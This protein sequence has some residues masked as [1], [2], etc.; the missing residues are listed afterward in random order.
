MRIAF[1]ST[2]FGYPWGGADVLW[3]RAAARALAENHQVLVAVSA[4]CVVHPRIAALQAAGAELHV[5]TGFT[6]QR[7]R[8]EQWLQV[9][10]R[11][12]R[13]SRSLTAT[14]DRFQPDHLFLAQGGVFD[15][16]V[17]DGLVR[18]LAT[19]R[20]TCIPICQ[21]NDE[22]ESVAPSLQPAARQFLA[23]AKSTVFVSTH[24]RD[25]AGRQSGAPVP[26]AVVVA[27]PVEL[28]PGPPPPW[29]ANATPQLAIVAR[30]ESDPKGLDVLLQALARLGPGGDWHVDL[31]GRGPDEAA[32]RAEAARLGL[33][34][35]LSFSGYALN[36][37]QLWAD[38]H[39][40]LL[41]SRRE[42]CALAM[43]EALACGRPVLTTEIGGARDW[44]E[45]GVNGYL[46]PP[47]DT[48]AFATTLNKALA[49]FTRWPALGEG[50]RKIFLERHPDSP[51]AQLLALL[52]S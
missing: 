35:R 45:P 30:L 22:R 13:S 36:I 11:A 10:A 26:R 37:R 18:W 29:P 49:E 4:M 19:G 32:L 6:Q 23:C 51:E 42:G 5:R 8:R 28:P 16:L 43:L 24:N 17:E 44:I 39:L 48:G 3:T 52:I 20:C 9:L 2:I 25:H 27:N 40:L 14:L 38:H 12:L 50:A 46:C 34:G 47:G 1:V 41:P 31:F 15:F 21:S 7:G 33:A